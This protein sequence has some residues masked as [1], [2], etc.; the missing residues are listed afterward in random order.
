M[1]I[2]TAG[3]HDR[4]DEAA[5]G[6]PVRD[7]TGGAAAPSAAALA[8]LGW[9]RSFLGNAAL[10][11][12]AGFAV[13]AASM[14]GGW[15]MARV[16][17][18]ATF[19]HIAVLQNELLLLSLVSGFGLSVGVARVAA[20][21]DPIAR[22][23]QWSQFCRLR[24][25][26][27]GVPLLLAAGWSALMRDWLHFGA[28]FGACALMLQDFLATSLQASGRFRAAAAVL[29]TQA[30]TFLAGVLVLPADAELAVP[31]FLVV[32]FAS[33]ALACAVGAWQALASGLWIV[34]T[35]SL[36]PPDSAAILKGSAGFQVISFLQVGF[37]SLPLIWLGSNQYYH[38]AGLLAILLTL[39]RLVP[40]IVGP[41][42]TGFYFPTLCRLLLQRQ[43]EQLAL[44]HRLFFTGVAMAGLAATVGLAAAPESVISLIYP[45]AYL[46][47]AP[48]LAIMAGLSV[49]LSLEVLATWG[50][51]AYGQAA[52]ASA[53]LGLRLLVLS[54]ALVVLGTVGHEH[55]SL[56][57]IGLAY[58]LACSLS[59]ILQMLGLPAPMRVGWSITPLLVAIGFGVLYAQAIRSLDVNALVSLSLAAAG[60]LAVSAGLGAV[61]YLS[62]QSRRQALN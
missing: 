51:V 34:R 61:V 38:E 58:L 27:F 9:L 26:T 57:A 33:L 44:T 32:N 40:L 48:T 12:G 22:R 2:S 7:S 6:R 43:G 15:Y 52:R 16:L 13:L 55:M 30:V 24:V 46:T 17:G 56:E 21:S 18:P 14:L 11:T 41:A 42:V 31:I 37:G 10:T 50:A 28:A 5:P 36:L 29:L 19:G 1:G 54:A 45:A 23:G 60:A 49:I 59:V 53:I 39:V 3:R 25:L 8:P 35:E 4:V 47:A 20:G 62:R